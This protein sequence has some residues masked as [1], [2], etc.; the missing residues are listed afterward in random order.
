MAGHERRR[1]EDMVFLLNHLAAAGCADCGER[2]PV[3]LEFDHVDGKRATIS[4]IVG[5]WSRTRL[6]A[7][8]AKCEVRCANCHARRTAK[9][10]RYYQYASFGPNFWP[11][12]DCADDN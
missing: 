1:R 3:V 6:I 5:S 10:L 11:G 4:A 7:E 8:M 2:D 12:G 9:Q